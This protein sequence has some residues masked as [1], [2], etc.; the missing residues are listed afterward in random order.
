MNLS[1]IYIFAL[2]IIFTPHFILK[3]LHKNKYSFMIYSLLFSVVFYLTYD[4]V[5]HKEIEGALLTAYDVH[6]NEE[7][8]DINNVDLGDV[9]L[10]G[11]F[12]SI[13]KPSGLIYTEQTPIG[14]QPASSLPSLFNR[15]ALEQ[16]INKLFIPSPKTKNNTI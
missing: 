6:G 10:N 2:F 1:I 11:G 7:K 9:N 8:V 12:N 16:N 5:I 3:V 15:Y 14:N 13:R 4:M